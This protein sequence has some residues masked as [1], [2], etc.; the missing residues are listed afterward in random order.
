MIMKEVWNSWRIPSDGKFSTK[1]IA[2][3]N[4]GQIPPH[5][6]AKLPSHIWELKLIP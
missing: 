4:S 1:T 3:A 2:W 6:R 5:S